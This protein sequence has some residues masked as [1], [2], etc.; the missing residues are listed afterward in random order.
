[1]G[2]DA[3][4]YILLSGYAEEED[5]L[6]ASYCQEL[7]TASCGDTVLEALENLGEA[8]AEHLEGLAD[9]GELERTLRERQICVQS[10]PPDTDGV[11]VR[12]PPGRVIKTYL[13]TVPLVANAV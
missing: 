13:H 9:V 4:G 8:I 1:M 10:R 3:I 11:E 2:N 5:G 12:I 7:G 6:F